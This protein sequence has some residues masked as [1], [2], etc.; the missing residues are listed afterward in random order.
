MYA[1]PDAFDRVYI[2][3]APSPK[4]KTRESEYKVVSKRDVCGN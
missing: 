2:E 3:Y 1:H 4:K